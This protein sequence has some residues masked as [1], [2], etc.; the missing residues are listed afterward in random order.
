MVS[1]IF[2]F[3]IL[4]LSCFHHFA[5]VA[6]SGLSDFPHHRSVTRMGI[7][8]FDVVHVYVALV[9]DNV[10]ASH[11][12]MVSMPYTITSCHHILELLNIESI[13]F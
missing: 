4:S 9:I 1:I 7:Q 6:Q 5:D 11:L 13:A 2:S 12:H 8:Q 3:L 10:M